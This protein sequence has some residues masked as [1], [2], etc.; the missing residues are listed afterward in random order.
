MLSAQV[1][2]TRSQMNVIHHNANCLIDK[3]SFLANPGMQN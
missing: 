1:Q 3:V 2:F